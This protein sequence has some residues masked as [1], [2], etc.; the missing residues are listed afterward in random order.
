MPT[1]YTTIS[2]ATLAAGKP[3]TQA[4]SRA[5]RDNPSAITE[6]SSG[7]PKIQTAAL[8]TAIVTLPKLST[9]E[10]TGENAGGV[11]LTAANTVIKDVALGTLSVGDL[12]LVG[13]KVDVQVTA[14]CTRIHV[15]IENVGTGTIQVYNDDAELA[16]TDVGPQGGNEQHFSQFGM[17]RV[18]GA[19][20]ITLRLH[21]D[22]ATVNSTVNAGGGRLHAYVLKAA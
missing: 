16:I 14:T 11:T 22:S 17:L 9:A 10:A 15:G 2:D 3:L 7:A 5:L 19:G 4:V 8:D 12:I 6:G 20:T 21:G 1:S 18:T 13:Y